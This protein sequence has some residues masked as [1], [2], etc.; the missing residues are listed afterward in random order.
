MVSKLRSV[1]TANSQNDIAEE[2]D[3]VVI[4]TYKSVRLAH[5]AGLAVLA[6]GHH[7]WVYQVEDLYALAVLPKHAE[8]LRRE[9]DIAQLK[10]RFWPPVSIDLPNQ[11]T[12]KTPTVI[13]AISLLGMFTAQNAIPRLKDVG[14]NSSEGV[15]Q[16]GEWWRIVTAITLHADLAHLAGNLLGIAFFTYLC[17]RYMGNGLAWFLIVLVASFSNLTNAYIRM[18]EPFFSLGASTAVFA[19]L[20]LLAGFPVGT[21]L[22]TRDPMQ[23]RD[24]L[25]PFFGG[26]IL[27]A[28]M[29]GGEFPTDV[30]GH[31]LSFAFGTVVAIGIAGTSIPFK[32][33]ALHQKALLLTSWGLIAFSWWLAL[34]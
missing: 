33:N 18:G 8:T 10:N 1:G 5:E 19:A 6:A 25:V 22:K 13:F 28:W 26:C 21:F 23:N 20:G 30:M 29:G 15:F 27:F 14:M 31:V 9:V 17:C 2:G 7:Y 24:W 34:R 12:R 16:N 32:L 4:G 11:S 3:F